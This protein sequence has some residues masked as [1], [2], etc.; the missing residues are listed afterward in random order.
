MHGFEREFRILA[1]LGRR[2]AGVQARG[3]GAGETH[4]DADAR[5]AWQGVSP[6]ARRSC[7]VSGG[8]RRFP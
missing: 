3:N 6:R 8:F 4:E 1:C 2:G 7:L 5:A